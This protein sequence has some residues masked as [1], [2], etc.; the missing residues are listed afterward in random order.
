[1]RDIYDSSI[2]ETPFERWLELSVEYRRVHLCD[3]EADSGDRAKE[4][5]RLYHLGWCV[6]GAVRHLFT[7]LCD[8]LDAKM[9]RSLR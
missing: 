2:M 6:K 7:C 9:R 8:E 3:I 5:Q 4:M 1:M